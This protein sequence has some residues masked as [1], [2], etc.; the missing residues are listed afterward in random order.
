MEASHPTFTNPFDDDT[1]WRGYVALVALVA[2]WLAAVYLCSR[3]MDEAMTLAQATRFDRYDLTIHYG[4]IA[5][6]ALPEVLMFV[7][8]LL[9]P[10]M[11]TSWGSAGTAPP[12]SDLLARLQSAWLQ[13]ARAVRLTLTPKIPQ[14]ATLYGLICSISL[15]AALS[16][17]GPEIAFRIKGIKDQST[18][19]LALAV[20]VSAASAVTITFARDFGRSVLRSAQRDISIRTLAAANQ[21]L[22]VTLVFAAI[23]ACL[24][25]V[26]TTPVDHPKQGWYAMMAAIGIAVALGGETIADALTT[27]AMGTLGVAPPRRAPSMLDELSGLLPEDIERLVEEGISSVHTL[28]FYPTPR[29]FMLT[30]FSLGELCEWQDQALLIVV[31]GLARTKILRDQLGVCG[32]TAARELALATLKAEVA[33]PAPPGRLPPRSPSGASPATMSST[34]RI[35]PSSDADLPQIAIDPATDIEDFRKMLGFA[36]RVQLLL[37]LHRVAHDERIEQLE[38]YRSVQIEFVRA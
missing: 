24:S 7:A 32:A 22:L 5:I 8:A 34:A 6:C 20:A 14:Y 15:L 35:P 3:Q 4:G 27:R 30:R 38:G 26:A 16:V 31:A 12:P 19:L 13:E 11:S 25:F 2:L 21:R 9:V 36:T 33:R 17:L 18:P 28:A 1:P 29:L 37:F 23:G 10:K